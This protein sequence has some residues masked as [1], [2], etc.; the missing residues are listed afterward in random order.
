MASQRAASIVSLKYP[1]EEEKEIPQNLMP[2]KESLAELAGSNDS[3]VVQ[4]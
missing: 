4:V 3:R 2:V 1:A